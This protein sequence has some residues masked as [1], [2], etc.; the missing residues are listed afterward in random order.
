[1]TT[2][3]RPESGIR[4]APRDA[5]NI[6]AENSRIVANIIDVCI[7]DL[8]E[9]SQTFT[10]EVAREWMANRLDRSPIF[11]RRL[12][13]LPGDVGDPYW[14]DDPT[15]A[16]DQHVHVT[17]VKDPGWEPVESALADLLSAPMDLE[18]SA[19]EVH[20]LTGIHGVDGLPD[21]CCAAVVKAH[22]SAT[23]GLG[24]V[25]V[26]RALFTD[27]R[28]ESVL[29]RGD[30]RSVRIPPLMLSAVRAPL[31]YASFAW[32]MAASRLHAR[33]DST[34]SPA[35]TTTRFNDRVELE[36]WIRVLWLS[37]DG[38]RRISR[39]VP[40]ATI[41]D[42]AMTMV[43]LALD[44]YLDLPRASFGSTMPLDTH[45]VRDSGTAN[46]TH[47]A[48]VDLHNDVEDPHARLAAIRESTSHAKE[49]TRSS[50]VAPQPR[51][52][53]KIPPGVARLLGRLATIRRPAPP[54]V[55]ATTVIS[56]MPHGKD[57]LTLLG[58]PVVGAFMPM[59][60]VDGMGLIHHV[61]SVG[62][63]LALTV[64][65]EKAMM[66]DPDRYL[67]ILRDVY[68]ELTRPGGSFT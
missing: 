24:L 13:R 18:D 67:A 50:E 45:D 6:F 30:Q 10:A 14:I 35:Y 39:T 23:D 63:S 9:S 2:R 44:R 20:F 57:D 59:P 42:V 55:S 62:D 33:R 53:E 28:T 68:T 32:S 48:N 21:D 12:H 56:N 52:M 34:P 51:P 46:Q 43:S 15:P 60:T 16:M 29:P 31:S 64:T 22:H 36:Q 40:G 1:M 17:A 66:P 61:A 47:F 3:F 25:A 58:A 41:N 65:V 11:T 5:L 7:F 4:V 49:L 37:V 38:M 27:D 26:V 8:A 19:W 54:A